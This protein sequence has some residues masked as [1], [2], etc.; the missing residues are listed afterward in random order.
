MVVI[1]ELIC[2]FSPRSR[3]WFLSNFYPCDLD[4]AGARW[5][6]LEHAYQACKAADPV[7]QER[8]R[9]AQTPSQAKRLGR[10]CEMRD[11]WED[12]KL[13]VM[14]T[15]LQEKFADIDLAN[16]LCQ[17]GSAKLVEGNAWGDTFWGVCNGEGENWL[18]KLLMQLRDELVMRR[19]E[20]IATWQKA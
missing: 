13:A 18:G 6:T 9:L 19:M 2:D 20:E 4:F 3:W 7:W 14:Y 10:Q 11:G 17:T 12:I 5:P 16:R 15:L 1:P 8:I